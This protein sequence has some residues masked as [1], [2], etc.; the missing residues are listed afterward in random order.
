VNYEDPPLE[1]VV[2]KEQDAYFQVSFMRNNFLAISHRWLEPTQPDVGGEQ[3]RKLKEYLARPE[4]RAIKWVWYD[5]WCMPQH[6]P[7]GTEDR[8]Q[9]DL[10]AFRWMLSNVDLLY[11]SA[12]VLLMVD[13][14]Y[15]SRFW[16]QFEAWLSFQTCAD[17]GLQPANLQTMRCT[18]VPILNGTDA[19]CNEVRLMW[20][21][22][23]PELAHDVLSLPDVTVTNARDKAMFLPRLKQMNM[24]VMRFRQ[25]QAR[26]R[27]QV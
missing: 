26:D 24:T 15:V 17:D 3:M 6:S 7:K 5:Y 16:T 13:L 14:S 27:E 23:T 4:N 1:R 8:S 19:M 20:M 11:L 12:S 21:G 2:V 22:K 25:A 10:A 9:A 18:M